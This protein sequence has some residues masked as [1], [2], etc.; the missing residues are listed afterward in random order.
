MPRFVI[1]EHD[2]PH[3]HWDLML[4][5]GH[6]LRTWRLAKPPQAGVA[7][8]AEL[9][10]DHRIRYLDYE[11]PLSNNRGQVQQ[12]DSGTYS[13]EIPANITGIGKLEIQLQGNRIKGKCVLH[14]EEYNQWLF[15]L[16]DK[17]PD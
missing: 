17:E 2:H 11:G 10:S 16:L 12:W 14:R 15:Q 4:Q 1:L 3:L 9:I 7:I 5:V 13:D 8:M 6:I